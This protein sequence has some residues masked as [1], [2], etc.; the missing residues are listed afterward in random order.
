MFSVIALASVAAAA[1]IPAGLAAYVHDQQLTGYDYA[2]SDLNGDGRPEALVYARRGHEDGQDVSLCGSGGCDLIVLS[3]TPTGYRV[4]SDIS[5]TRPPIRVL[6][7]VSHGWHD[8]SVL[9]AGGGILPGY[10]A[11]LQFDGKTYP[12][13]PS[14]P[15]ALRMKRDGQGKTVITADTK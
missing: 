6:P 5:I 15:P 13:N 1:P 10:R 9:V 8:L 11:R 2:L 3:L 12:A 4:I 14:V 7:S